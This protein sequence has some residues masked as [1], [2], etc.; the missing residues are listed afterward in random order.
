LKNSILTIVLVIIFIVV[1]CSNDKPNEPNITLIVITRIVPDSAFS[2]DIVSITGTGFGTAQRVVSFNGTKATDYTNWNDTLIK[3]KVPTGAASGKVWIIIDAKNSNEVDFTIRAKLSSNIETAVIPS[4]SMQMGNTGGYTGGIYEDPTHTVTL[5]KSYY[6][7]KYE[8][9]QSQWIAIMGT[10][11]S[12]FKGDNLPVETV[13]W[14]DAVN[15][16]NK[17]SEID[18]LTKCYSIMDS[19]NV[20]CNWDANGWRLPTEAEW[21]FACKAGTTTDYYNG[22]LIN[23]KISPLDTALDKIGWYGGNSG[24]TTHPVGLKQPNSY[25]LYDMSGNVYEWCWDWFESDYKNS[26]EIDPKGAS[27]GAYH[28]LRSGSWYDNAKECRSSCREWNS[29]D[30]LNTIGFRVCRNK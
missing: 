22:N 9:T 17:I 11:P 25:G 14:F 1:S 29:Y 18:G 15:Y 16:C 6:M 20:I 28:S 3:V 21:E 30:K 23:Y 2:G 26:L 19:I 8:V 12:S 5:T 4:G 27:S 10:N 7:G 13:S 24:Y